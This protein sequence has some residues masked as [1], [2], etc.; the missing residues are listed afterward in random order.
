MFLSMDEPLAA[1]ESGTDEATSGRVVPVGFQTVVEKINAQLQLGYQDRLLEPADACDDRVF[2]RRIYLDLVG[3]IPKTSELNAF[4]KDGSLPSVRRARL[5]DQLLQSEEHVIHWADL[6]DTLLMGRAAEDKYMKRR[7]H[8]WRAFLENAVRVNQPWN[9]F[10]EEIIL[11]RPAN[12]ARR[13]SNWFLFERNNDFQQ[14]AEAVAPAVFGIRIECAQCHDHMLVDE[15]KQ[16]HYWGLVAFFN[17]GKNENTNGGPQVAE[18]AIGGFS[19]FA[20]LLGDSTPNLLTFLDVDAV[21][22]QR[23]G[24]DE[25]QSDS[26]DLYKPGAIE[27]APRVPAFSRREKFVTEVVRDHPRV[28]RALVNRVWALLMGRGI[29]HPYDEMDS[30][31]D[32]SHPELLDWLSQDFRDN[33][34]NVRRLVRAV[35][36]SDAYQLAS[37][38]P[39]GVDDPATFAYYLERSLTGEQLARSAQIALWGESS[40]DSGLAGVFRQQFPDLL[41]NDQIASVK[42]SLFLSNNQNIHDLLAS[43][44]QPSHLI[45]RLEKM[46]DDQQRVNELFQVM[47]ARAPDAEES[48]VVGS[49]LSNRA[50][51]T[52]AIRQVAWSMLT[53]AEFRYNH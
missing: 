13:G 48:T 49:F 34:Y 4:L 2:L 18:S 44:N 19:E 30:M 53:S 20:D 40:G 15:I 24:K 8:Q 9:E 25:K 43:S 26:D 12:E 52:E 17:R 10:V 22:E 7:Q 16:A 37:R 29:V 6:F 5:V 36:F 33:G 27:N 21:D 23:P 42:E 46:D 28:A 32:P 50:S 38:R 31:H 3:R 1:A 14:I 51:T 45:P 39:E 11:A 35:V 41:P 47:F